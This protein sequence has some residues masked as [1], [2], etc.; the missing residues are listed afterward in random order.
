MSPALTVAEAS[1]AETTLHAHLH[2]NF[3]ADSKQ[4]IR[5][6]FSPNDFG[7]VFPGHCRGLLRVGHG[8]EK[9]HTHLI[10]GL[11]GLKIDSR[12]RN[13]HRATNVVERVA[14]RVGGPDAHQLVDLAAAAGAPLRVRTACGANPG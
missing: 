3:E 4:A 9:T 8:N 14:L 11:A 12:P 5:E 2:Q 13:A 1:A 6:G 7:Q 10:G